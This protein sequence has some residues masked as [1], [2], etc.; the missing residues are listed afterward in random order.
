M[1][2]EFYSRCAFLSFCPWAHEKKISCQFDYACYQ[3]G[4][5]QQSHL[6]VASWM[7]A[8]KSHMSRSQQ[9][10]LGYAQVLA[11]QSMVLEPA[12]LGFQQKI[13]PSLLLDSTA[14]AEP[15]S[16]SS[17]PGTSLPSKSEQSMKLT[18]MM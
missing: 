16:G 15:S 18:F 8:C 11:V 3:E 5:L 14:Q 17:T 10:A 2:G 1:D 4:S 7:G 13:L 9:A 6:Y 12:T